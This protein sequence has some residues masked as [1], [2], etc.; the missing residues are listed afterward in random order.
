MLSKAVIDRIEGDLAIIF[1]AD[2]QRHFNYPKKELP[3]GAKEG[4]WLLVNV[5][6]EK[7]VKITL[8]ANSKGEATHRIAE[9]LDKLRHQ[10][11]LP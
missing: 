9:K 1:L 11:K 3:K 4:D 6:G 2:N 5:Q 8:D 10:N 7:I